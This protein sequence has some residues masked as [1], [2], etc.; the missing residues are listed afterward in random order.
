MPFPAD[1]LHLKCCG[2]KVKEQTDS[3]VCRFEIRANRREVNRIESFDG[4][5][6]DYAV[7]FYQ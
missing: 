5:Q 3:A 4:L 7:I 2:S 6:F 1:P